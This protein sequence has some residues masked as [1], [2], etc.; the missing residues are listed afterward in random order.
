MC[1]SNIR[2]NAET[3]L[4]IDIS[5]SIFFDVIRKLEVRFY[6]LRATEYLKV[7]HY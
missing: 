5:I 2:I 7:A 3:E 1:P 4:H 6:S